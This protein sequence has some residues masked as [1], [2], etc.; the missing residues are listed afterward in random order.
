MRPSLNHYDAAIDRLE[1]FCSVME[2]TGAK[3]SMPS[4]KRAHDQI[5]KIFNLYSKCDYHEFLRHP[6]IPRLRARLL[7]ANENVQNA[8][9][10]EYAES[11]LKVE[12]NPF[13]QSWINPGFRS[14]LKDQAT[15]W[16][17]IGALEENVNK[18]IVIVGGGALPQSQVTLHRQTSRPIISLDRNM[19]AVVA[20]EKLIRHLGYQR[21]LRVVH[22][23]GE[24]YDY[25]GAGLVV[26]AG[27]VS[28]KASVARTV[29]NSAPYAYLNIRT[30][31][32]L[33]CLW[34]TPITQEELVEIGWEVLDT[35]LPPS[36]AILAFTCK[37]S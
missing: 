25:G 33:H 8:S 5:I 10:L 30:P 1:Q 17:A 37:A 15:R 34:R 16:R 31:A 6:A 36:S 13:K 32:S 21:H 2:T 7:R 23:D 9:E 27:M 24:N 26:V 29:R 3:F 12:G 35:F 28:E 4:V 11:A 22:C 14:L 19:T 18:P 20:A